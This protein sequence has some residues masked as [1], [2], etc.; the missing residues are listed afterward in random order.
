MNEP[1]RI[2]ALAGGKTLAELSATLLRAIDPDAIAEQAAGMPGASPAD[3]APDAFESAQQ[4]IAAACAPF[5]SPALRDALAQSQAGS[6]QT[7]DTVTIDIVTHHGYDDAAKERAAN[8]LRSFRDYIEQHRA[9]ITA[10]QILYS[11]PSASA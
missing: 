2:T 7:I 3:V 11:R 10:L 5:D 6:E 9:E 4:L 8:L 1:A